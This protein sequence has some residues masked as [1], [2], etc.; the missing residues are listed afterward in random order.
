MTDWIRP[1]VLARYDKRV[2]V[3]IISMP[4]HYPDLP[5]GDKQ[6]FVKVRMLPGDPM[7][8]VEVECHRLEK[9]NLKEPIYLHYASVCGNRAFPK[10]MLR[11]D[12]CQLT[13]ESAAQDDMIEPTEEVV[14]QVSDSK[15]PRW[16]TDRWNSFGW[17][18]TPYHTFLLTPEGLVRL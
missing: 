5:N 1:Y 17:Y 13:P 16:T 12:N 4:W 6:S 8:M 2:T 10:D 14:V 11:Y 3:E 9:S 7:S 18:L 15:T